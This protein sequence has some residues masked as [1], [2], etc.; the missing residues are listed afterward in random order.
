MAAIEIDNLLDILQ[1]KENDITVNDDTK[2]IIKILSAIKISKQQILRSYA[3]LSELPNPSLIN[4]GNIYY[5][6]AE[7]GLYVST[8][9]VW[10][11]IQNTN[12]SSFSITTCQASSNGNLTYDNTTGEFAFTPADL[13]GLI[14]LQNL[15]VCTN[16]ASGNGCLTY[17]NTTGEFAFTPADLSSVDVTSAICDFICLTDLSVCTN[18]A[19]GS[20]SLAYDDRTGEFSFTPPDLSNYPVT[21]ALCDFIC[22]TDL[23]II[24]G[25]PSGNGG[26]T[27]D[28]TSGEF[29]FNPADLSNKL[30]LLDLSVCTNTASGSGS[31]SYNNS[32]GEFA[33]TPADINSCFTNG[34]IC[35]L[36]MTG[37]LCGPGT[38]TIDPAAHGD[39]T[40][41]VI[42]A[43]NLQVDGTTTTVNSCTVEVVDKNIVL[44]CGSNNKAASD[45]AGITIDL[46]TDGTTNFTYN[47]TNDNWSLDK[48]LSLTGSLNYTEDILNQ[49]SADDVTIEDYQ[50]STWVTNSIHYVGVSLNKPGNTSSSIHISVLLKDSYNYSQI[51]GTTDDDG[52]YLFINGTKINLSQ[53][54]LSTLG[55]NSVINVPWG[56]GLAKVEV[57][58]SLDTLGLFA[59][60][61]GYTWG[62]TGWN[63]NNTTYNTATRANIFPIKVTFSNNITEFGYDKSASTT[64][65][66][67]NFTVGNNQALQL[68]SSSATM[69]GSLT[70]GGSL[71]VTDINANGSITGVSSLT[72]LTSLS[73]AGPVSL[74]GYRG[75]NNFNISTAEYPNTFVL[76]NTDVGGINFSYNGTTYGRLYFSPDDTLHVNDFST[77]NVNANTNVT[78]NLTVTGD[79]SANGTTLGLGD[80]QKEF[81]ATGAISAGEVVSLRNDGTVE[82]I[83]STNI[84][85]NV[86]SSTIFENVYTNHVS[87]IFDSNSNKVVIFYQ[88]EGNSYYGTAIV[89][90]VSGNTITF[91]TPV[92]FESAEAYDISATFDS[93]QNKIVIHYRDA[94]NLDKWTAIIGEVSGNSIT[95][96]TPVV[97][98]STNSNWYP[99]TFDSSQNKLVFNYYD[100]GNS[101]YGTAVV[102][103]V[104]GNSIT[105]GTPVVFNSNNSTWISSTFDSNSN[106]IVIAYSDGGN[107]GYGTVVVGT[108]SG[109]GITFGTPVVFN[110]SLAYRISS[111]FDSNS[112]KIVIAYTDGGNSNYGTVVVG[113]VSGNSITFGT[114]VVF[115]SS[116]TTY[117][118]T[119]FD[120]TANK[121]VISYSDGGNSGHG[122]VVVGTVSGTSIALGTPVVFNSNNSSWISSIFDSNANKIVI[123]YTD[124]GN[125]HIGTAF[126]FT[127]PYFAT[128]ADSWIG[129]AAE[130]IADTATGKIDLPGALNRS[131]SGLTSN[132]IYYVASDGSLTTTATQY[133]KIGRAYSATELQVFESYKQLNFA[134]QLIFGN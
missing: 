51:Y 83:T 55:A 70:L 33:F 35:N 14:C 76:S 49:P 124:G 95:F 61:S 16:S 67:V 28:N 60:Y 46:G 36:Y 30:E 3:L 96:G 106:K 133:G 8:G 38:F 58:D 128:N 131:Q 132:S 5:V 85:Q 91:G 56:N 17:D 111:T 42:I 102:G 32:T 29:I 127:V 71:T 72:G 82:S 98:D 112:N 78:G 103:T 2:E 54:E 43:G 105:F 81:V 11:R 110:S 113:E 104:S 130:N 80:N 74:S 48:T 118:D 77:F 15:N 50:Q 13:N 1:Q 100:T 87:A 26:L 4:K 24:S 134:S 62:M 109:T 90:E 34:S 6:E 115:E 117:I 89:G 52:H 108:V 99:S 64:L 92:V 31:L 12:L 125:S 9:S 20:G 121:V 86:G 120:A 7:N 129:I 94:G 65:P 22:L 37:T 84:Q 27:Y 116:V 119:T 97:F 101:S 73:V 75:S 53:S 79:I 69:N 59:S 25:A 57:G 114:P 44:S 107:S 19:S 63:T 122:T 39:N 93:F 41:T 88:D 47:N 126:V 23:T 21:G 66:V 123:A 45:G 18:A 10:V 40:G 68:T